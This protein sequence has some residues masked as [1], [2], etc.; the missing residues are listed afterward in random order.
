[1]KGY[2]SVHKI[3]D[4][5]I[6]ANAAKFRVY[7]RLHG[8]ISEAFFFQGQAVLDAIFALLA[9]L[10]PPYID[11]IFDMR[12]SEELPRDIFQL[13][14]QKAQETFR[15]YP[16]VH[17]V[18]VTK[19]DCPLWLQISEWKELFDKHG[20]RILAIFDNPEKAEAFLDGLRKNS[21]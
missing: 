5:Q 6:F 2:V 4:R 14:K 8:F 19:D 21:E 15:K 3:G 17:V 11:Y 16:Q 9:S 10:N 1:M 12:F 18:G 13:W 20:N 7:A